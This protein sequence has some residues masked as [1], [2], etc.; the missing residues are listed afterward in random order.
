[1]WPRP[2]GVNK[3][4]TFWPSLA[5]GSTAAGPITA[6]MLL[7]SSGAAPSWRNT[8]PTVSP[9]LSGTTRSLQS[10]PPGTGLVFGNSV[11]FSATARG[12]KLK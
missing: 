5:V 4:R 1:M 8:E 10:P 7:I 3:A 11:T 2:T 6:M 12:T 9:R